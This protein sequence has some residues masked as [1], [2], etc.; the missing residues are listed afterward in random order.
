MILVGRPYRDAN[1]NSSFVILPGVIVVRRV[2]AGEPS[3]RT[4]TSSNLRS[5]ESDMGSS[6]V[7]T[8]LLYRGYLDSVR[9]GAASNRA[10][11]LPATMRARNVRTPI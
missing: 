6:F 1:S 8:A 3:I 11:T 5:T 2:R 9:T 10:S 4:V 7:K